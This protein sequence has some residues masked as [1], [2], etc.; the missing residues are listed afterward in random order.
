MRKRNQM[1]KGIAAL[2]SGV[3][4]FGMTAGVIPGFED[5][6][7]SVR[8]ATG[9]AP[10]V[11]A[12]A[13]KQ[14]MMDGTFATRNDTGTAANIGVL[15]F[16]KNRAKKTQEWYILGRDKNVDGDNTVIFTVKD[17]IIP[18]TIKNDAQKYSTV[19]TNDREYVASYGTYTTA[20]VPKTVPCSHY[21]AS[22]LRTELNKIAGDKAC[23]ST[24][25]QNLLNT[26]KITTTY[27][28]DRVDYT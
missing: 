28:L 12:Y 6:M 17:G 20:K 5:S 8:A 16:G 25:Q 23:F 11:T 1:K 19:T 4:A 21:G 9:I 7:Q 22:T 3:L 2:L 26:T 18:L 13:T 27:T 15:A 10:S 14:Q 24:A